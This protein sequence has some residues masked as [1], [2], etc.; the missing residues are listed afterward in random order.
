MPN[1]LYLHVPFCRTRCTYCAFNTYTGQSSLIDD[2][3][4]ALCR[5]IQWVTGDDPV[6]IHTVYFGGGTP[7][8]LPG[9]LIQTCLDSCRAA[10]ALEPGSEITVE[11]NPGTVNGAYL[12]HLFQAGVNR[13]SIGMQSAHPHELRLFGRTHHLEDVQ[14]AVRAA[15]RAGFD[16][17]SLDLIYG[18]PQQSMTAWRESLETALTMAP[19]HISLYSLSIEKATPIQHLIAQ[20]RLPMPDPDLAADMYEWAHERLI[21]AG[22]A[23]YEIS[24][25]GKPCQHNLHVWRNRPY[26]GL[27]AGAHGYAG[28]TRYAN[29]LHPADY[30]RR[31]NAQQTARPF[32]LSAAAAEIETIDTAD[33]MAETM[34][35]GLRLTQ[36]GV[37]FDDFQARFG[38]DLHNVFGAAI[39]RLVNLGLLELVP[40]GRV[41]LTARGR[42]LG[43]RVF[44]EFL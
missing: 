32:P 1:A 39:T 29:V 2:Y 16:N 13:L 28:G 21:A 37:G 27:G 12:Q 38:R 30:V 18:I 20:N 11:A 42:L 41:R 34:M 35:M 5:E 9:A 23:Q 3:V 10:F 4:Q 7:S 36:E 43:N 44:A 31:I 17:I 25:W 22:L 19:D 24:N 40:T 15:R 33:E 6:A 26:L 14:A 8:V